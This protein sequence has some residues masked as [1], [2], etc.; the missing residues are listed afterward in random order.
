MHG[1]QSLFTQA[2]A[3]ER[4][5]E[6]SAPVLNNPPPIQPYAPDSWGPQ[7]A[8][9]QLAAPYH[10]HLPVGRH[11]QPRGAPML[12][13][14]RPAVVAEGHTC[15]ATGDVLG[16]QVRGV[17]AVAER[18]HVRG[19]GRHLVQQR[20]HRHAAPLGAQLGPA[21]DAV[22]VHSDGIPHGRAP[23]GPFLPSRPARVAA[24]EPSGLMV[25][26]CGD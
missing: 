15:L 10:W 9:D 11:Q 8:V 26:G 24:T 6:I 13:L 3:V 19:V 2:S 25:C 7:A 1:D 17:A 4:L 5:W 21:G 22:D 14:Q 23:A 12:G 20:V 16:R 18:Q